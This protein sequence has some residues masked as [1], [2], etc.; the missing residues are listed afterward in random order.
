MA[1]TLTSKDTN[2]ILSE[3]NVAARRNDLNN[4]WSYSVKVGGK[5]TEYTVVNGQVVPF[6]PG[7][8]QTNPYASTTPLVNGRYG[9]KADEMKG[10]TMLP[11]T[12]APNDPSNITYAPSLNFPTNTPPFGDVSNA[13]SASAGT[14]AF[15]DTQQQIATDRQKQVQAEQDALAKTTKPFLDK[16]LGAPSP[17]EARKA[18]Q[19]E[20]GINPEDYFADQKV[21]IAEIE[22]LTKDY[23]ATKAAMEQQIAASNDKLGSN[24]FINNQIAQIQRNAAPKLNMMSAN[25]NSK[26][27]TMQALQG[28][29]NSA[30]DFVNQAVQDATAEQKY[31]FDL[32]QTFYQIN[33]DTIDALDAPYAEAYKAALALSQSQYEQSVKNKQQIG[34]MMLAYP[35]A[36]ISMGDTIEQ[37]FKKAASSSQTTGD[38]VG[39]ATTGYR[40]VVRDSSGN[41]IKIEPISGGGSGTGTT[42]SSTS[43]GTT[44][45]RVGSTGDSVKQL[46]SFLGITADG[47]FGSKTDAAV[48]AFQAANGLTADGIVGPKTLAAMQ[49]KGFA[50]SL[51]TGSTTTTLPKLT[52]TQ[53]ETLLTMKTVSDLAN[54]LL[55]ETSLPG[56]GGAYF[57]SL[58]QFITNTFGT[59]IEGQKIRNVVGN[60]QATIAKLRG[61]TSFTANEQKLL[62]TYVPT[63]NDSPAQ[64]KSKLTSLVNFINLQQSNLVQI[65][66]GTINNTSS[67]VTSNDPLGLFK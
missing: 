34:E 21:K 45:L 30:Q 48:K 22:T 2:N 18:A 33:K 55:S 17:M 27:A 62:E 39:T 3:Y 44:T 43:T 58:S 31:N 49:A 50:G 25:I 36:G 41:I 12:T 9:T 61:G 8:A 24:N 56:V 20:T 37:A 52:A 67:N 14:Q 66:S 23:N 65:A 54:Q 15:V 57:G 42:G 46:Q 63:I 51:S 29:F 47:Q 19:Q 1:N 10:Y 38:I 35:K 5:V 28:N 6:T 53:Q 64:I 32:Y 11:K 7:M 26:A 4:D 59:G 60:I 16:L 40:N 13:T